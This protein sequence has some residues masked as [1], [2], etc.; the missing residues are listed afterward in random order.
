MNFEQA[1]ELKEKLKSDFNNLYIT[2]KNNLDFKNYMEEFKFRNITDEESKVF[3]SNKLFR[4]TSIDKK[5][6]SSFII[7]HHNHQH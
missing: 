4:V 1:K 5:D 6:I 3:S 7:K 2:P